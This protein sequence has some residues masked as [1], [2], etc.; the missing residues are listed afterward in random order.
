M[1]RKLAAFLKGDAGRSAD[2]PADMPPLGWWHILRRV[3]TQQ[4]RK[5]IGLLSAGIAFY[6][7]LA[8]FP[9]LGA[10]L[11]IWGI[12]FDPS[13]ITDLVASLSAFLPSE[14]LRIISDQA[15]EITKSDA[16]TLGFGIFLG[17]AL[18]VFSATK[19]IKNMVI[20]LNAAYGEFEKR[21]FFILNLTVYGMTFGAIICGLVIMF[22]LL[23]IPAV[24]TLLNLTGVF[25]LLA[26]YI[27]WPVM[28]G[29]VLFILAFLY[30]FA[31]SRTS[32]K[33]QWVSVGSMAATCLWVAASLGFTY[34]VA[35]FGNYNETYGSLG[36]VA[37]LLLWL[38]IS[39]Y[40]VLIG[41]VLNAEI[42]HQTARDSTTGPAQ[43][44]G[45][46]GAHMADTLGR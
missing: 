11:S 28:F 29:F 5:N 16:G 26:E 2:S 23:I 25:A 18:A 45:R 15:Q 14:L 24:L 31:P 8:L 42:E 38:W 12:F 17:L 4:Q 6:A 41:A 33:W 34:Y 39:A 27:R 19:G 13:D 10:A 20:G 35:H 22:L 44:M 32:P 9:A 7:L 21:N 30:R 46:R 40:M 3:W 37:I 1:H 36:A 43:P